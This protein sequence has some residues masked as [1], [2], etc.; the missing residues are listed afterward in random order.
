VLGVAVGVVLERGSLIRWS[1]ASQRQLDNIAIAE[2]QLPRV[3][4]L[5]ASDPRFNDVE[6]GA[7]TGQDGAVGLIGFVSS[8]PTGSL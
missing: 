1:A 5:L 8:L 6:A 7:Y 2:R 4:A 3:K